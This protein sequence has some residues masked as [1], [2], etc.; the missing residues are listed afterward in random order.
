MTKT[1]VFVSSVMEN[2]V[3]FREAARAGILEAGGEPVLVEDFPSLS[4]SA[5]S[6]CLDGVASSDVLIVI[7]GSRGGWTAPSGKV[8]VE[9]EYEEALKKK[10]PVISFILSVESRDTDAQRLV[11]RVS[12]YVDGH[13]RHIF[14]TP[15]EL[16]TLIIKALRPMIEHRKWS[17]ND[18]IILNN[19][20]FT[21][22]KID[23]E[24][25]M[26]FVCMPER[27]EKLVDEIEIASQKFKDDLLA[28]A[29]SPAVR[30]FSYEQ[31]KTVTLGISDISIHQA[32]QD[33]SRHTRDE[34]IANLTT[35]GTITIDCNVTGRR[36][37]DRTTQNSFASLHYLLEKDIT[38]RL[39]ASIAF[40]SGIYDLQDRYKRF[41]RFYYNVALSN[42]QSRT[43]VAELPNSSSY[44][45]PPSV[46]QPIIIF[47]Q[48]RI[49]SR[50]ELTDVG[51]Q[52]EAI[53]SLLRRRMKSL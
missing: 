18:V 5:R 41:D 28:L 44:S 21:V 14:N 52:I 8:V 1:R 26:R 48:H 39:E 23:Y 40:T 17:M 2:F 49:L 42:I 22:P 7:I 50:S 47:D 31:A 46:M 24:V 53:L 10:I 33:K 51:S 12:D 43:L 35:A 9:E 3:Q 37:Y 16:Q 27:S 34:V 45:Y 6:A 13:F 32:A 11:E 15:E 4:I 19:L 38:D 36:F 29:H 25:V 20:L 30:L